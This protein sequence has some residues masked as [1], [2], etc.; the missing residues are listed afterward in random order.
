MGYRSLPVYRIMTVAL[1]RLGL[2]SEAPDASP[3]PP[4]VLLYGVWDS[5]ILNT[6]YGRS[7]EEIR[8]SDQTLPARRL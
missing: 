6:M 7:A 1:R 8:T 3:D 2:P 5:P 4:V